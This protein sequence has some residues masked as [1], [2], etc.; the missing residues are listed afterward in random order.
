M[1]KQTPVSGFVGLRR[2]PTRLIISC[3]L[4]SVLLCLS[5]IPVQAQVLYGSLTGNVT[6][7]SGAA[8]IGAKVEAVNIATGVSRTVD[9]NS[10]GVYIFPALQ[11][12]TY[13]V[14]ITSGKF[15]TF[16]NE[17]VP[18]GVN[19]VVRIDASLKVAGTSQD[20]TVTA[21]APVLQTDKAD[22][23]TDLSSTQITDLPVM[24][25]VAG[26]NFQGLLKIV[27]G[28]GN[29]A[30]ANSAGGNPQRAMSTNVNGQSVNTS[31][32]RIDGAQDAYPWLPQNVAYV[33]PADAIEAVNVVTNSFDPEQGMA[34]GAAVNVQIKSGTNQF[35]GSAFEFYNSNVLRTRNYF[36]TD[37]TRFPTKPRNIKNEYGFT[38]GGPIVKNKLFF[39]TD[40]DRNTQRQLA[41]STI[42]LPTDAFRRGDFSS[43][44]PLGAGCYVTPTPTGCVPIYDP[45]NVVGGVRQPFPG[46]IIP[47]GRIDPAAVSMM[48]GLPALTNPNA[49]T[50]NYV[51]RGTGAFTRNNYDVK[52]NYNMSQKSTIFGRYSIS[53]SN[54]FDPPSL[55]IEGGDATAGGQL[56]ES[57]SRIQS[58]GLGGTYTIS[59]SMVADW[60]FGFT[61]QRLGAANIDI[62]KAYGLDTLH[63]PGTN[64]AGTSGDPSLYNGYP[65]FSVTNMSNMGN[66]NTGNPFQF[67]DNQYVTGVNLSYNRGKHNFRFGFEYNHTQLNHFQ[68]QGNDGQFQTA[69]GS[70]NFNGN[71]TTLNGTGPQS[72]YNSLAQFL[73]GLPN[74]AGKAV[75]LNNPN[76]MRWT[77]YAWYVRDQWQVLPKLTLTLGLRWED[78][79][80]GYSDNGHGLPV[81]IPATGNVY[82]GGYGSV[83]G[84][85]NLETSGGMWLPRVG[86]AY[87]LTN[88]TVIRAGYGMSADPNNWRWLRNAYPNTTSTDIGSGGANTAAV[89]LT[90]LNATGPYAGISTGLTNQLPLMNL[91]ALGGVV[92]LPANAGTR[93]EANPFDRGYINSYNLVVQ[94][95]LY[96]FNIEAGYVGAM[97]VR[98]LSNVNM[99]SSVVCPAVVNGVARTGLSTDSALCQNAGYGRALNVAL[100]KSWADISAMTPWKNNYYNAFQSKLNRRFSNGS[101]FGVVY[102]F[103]K[104]INYSDDD[105][106]TG[107]FINQPAYFDLNKGLARFDR[108]HNFQLYGVWQLPFGKGQKY[109]NGG[110]IKDIFIGGWQASGVMSR[111]SGTPFTVTGSASLLNPYINS[112]L[113]N[114]AQIVGN[115]AV[116]DGKPWSL[117]GACPVTNLSCHYFDPTVFA[118][119]GLGVFGNSHRNQFRGPGIFNAD[120]SLLKNFT[121]T[122][123]FKFQFRTDIF[124]LTNTPRFNNPN[125]GCGS[126]GAG[127]NCTTG[128]ASNNNLGTITGT[129]GTSGSN[130]STDGT[131]TIWFSGKLIF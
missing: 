66:A 53:T 87:R 90:G 6:D 10:T 95:E 39:F 83:P 131:R 98:P 12:G 127:T 3:C 123:R 67:R 121:I 101:Q 55:G 36:Q 69:R 65:F 104:T 21:E 8:V 5:V 64:G 128:V 111:L 119:P 33:P 48:A 24:S 57:T 63:I 18:V 106:L 71:L 29:I 32:T 70:F 88:K 2:G 49:T 126:S 19:T 61:R 20:V 44:L 109:A 125:T 105:D 129:N 68:P 120:L 80:F 76:A 100:G 27:P 17:N 113:S 34:G 42:T 4:F 45:N 89:S 28:F 75:Y 93:T 118:Q 52:I 25:S 114:T 60:N 41:T 81:F 79:P 99:N 78:Y 130:A 1:C 11:A 47:T 46:N 91:T 14:T 40:Y 102:T 22:V 112:G 97:A 43:L 116:L 74:R 107:T 56:G 124:S 16:V 92:P 62:D 82:V 115:Y 117:T 94:Q 85:S 51:P 108:P 54:I 26:R 103:S 73:L 38:L 23:H 31:N 96:G 35:H 7:A 58:V 84:N 37:L 50:N 30:E 122:E 86:A 110:G 15:A 77:Q 9:S 72:Y 59:N 13:K